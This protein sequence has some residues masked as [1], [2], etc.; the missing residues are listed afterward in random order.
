MK[1]RG[2]SVVLAGL[3]AACA[4]TP[5]QPGGD[6][7]RTLAAAEVDALLEGRGMGMAAI[8]E[9]NGY[10]GPMHVLELQDKLKLT[11]DQRFATSRLLGITQ[12]RVRALGARIVETERQLDADMA[13]GTL[14]SEQLRIRIQTIAAL[15]GQLRHVHADA[16]LRGKAVLPPVLSQRALDGDGAVE[17]GHQIRKGDEK[18]ITGMVD[19]IARSEQPPRP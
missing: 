19:F 18:A 3:L 14:T 12:G 5:E 8:A 4:S 1:A 10:P 16:H 2:L 7:S 17:P 11:P 15:R 9:I 6:A 13:S